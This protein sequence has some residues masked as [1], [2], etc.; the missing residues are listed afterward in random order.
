MKLK[1]IA[2]G[3][4]LA[5]A[6]GFGALGVGAGLAQA[7]PPWPPGPNVPGPGWDHDNG[8]RGDHDWRANHDWRA[9][10]GD[11]DGVPADWNNFWGPPP[12][13]SVPPPAPIWAPGLA[14]VWNPDVGGWGVWNSGIFI[15]L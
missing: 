8:W 9:D 11:W 2:A 3:T 7:D 13:A 14:V 4:A 15:Q 10:R 6:L 1:K 12:W 5:G